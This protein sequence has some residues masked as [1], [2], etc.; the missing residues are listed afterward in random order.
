VARPALDGAAAPVRRAR[1]WLGFGGPFVVSAGILGFLVSRLDTGSVFPLVGPG[2]ATVLVPALLVYGAATLLLEAITLRRATGAA[3]VALGL[4]LCARLK[5]AS[6]PL[7]L[8]H[9]GLGAASLTFL[10]RRRGGLAVSRAAGVVLLISAFDL[11]VLLCLTA[12]G[13]ALLATQAPALRAGAVG[14][15]SAAILAGLVL[16]RAPGSLG[17]LE[18]LRSLALFDAVRQAEERLLLELAALRLVFVLVFVGLSAAALA[19]FGV[20]VPAGDLVV[21]MAA[22]T[23]VTAL[24]I[25]LAGLGTGQAAFVYLFRHWAPAEV[26]LACSLTLS[27]GLIALRAAMGLV[28][29]RE[30]TREALEAAREGRA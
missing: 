21:G 24:P 20:R 18:R 1:R 5:A 29:A 26:L 15:T 28:F 7:S 30:F 19:A 13:A 16:L 12:L 10:L 6:Y 25:A 9:Y 4:G 14:G 8:V 23:L 17:P 2:V 22:V 11:A 27:A 3:G